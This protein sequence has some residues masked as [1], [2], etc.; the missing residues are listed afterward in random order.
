MNGLF[1][2]ALQV[3]NV[4]GAYGFDRRAERV[5]SATALAYGLSRGAQ[6]AEDLRPIEPLSFTMLAEVHKSSSLA[7]HTTRGAPDGIIF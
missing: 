5:I 2:E 4:Q 7:H 6:D 3:R 1:V